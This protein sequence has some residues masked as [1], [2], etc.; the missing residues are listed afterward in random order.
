MFIAQSFICDLRRS[1]KNDLSSSILSSNLADSL[2]EFA[3]FLASCNYSQ[4]KVIKWSFYVI[5]MEGSLHMLLPNGDFSFIK[6]REALEMFANN[7]YLST[8]PITQNPLSSAIDFCTMNKESQPIYIFLPTCYSW[9]EEI[10]KT[11][12]RVNMIKEAKIDFTFVLVSDDEKTDINELNE[13]IASNPKINL[14]NFMNR[15]DC[16]FQFFR[17]IAESLFFH[18]TPDI[19]EIGI[20]SILCHK[21]PLLLPEVVISSV[22]TCTCHNL[23]SIQKNS[24]YCSVSNKKLSTSQKKEEYSLCGFIV[25]YNENEIVEPKFIV[26][27]RIDI[28][29]ISESMLIGATQILT[30]SD[31]KFHRI[32]NELRCSKEAFIAVRYPSN[33]F[34]G[35]YFIIIPDPSYFLLHCKKIG[36]RCQVLKFDLGESQQMPTEIYT[37][38]ISNEIP[39]IDEINPFMLGH[40]ELMR[41]FGKKI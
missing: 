15:D 18:P 37:N 33:V 28:K 10:T 16:F 17:S 38:E 22:S 1:D 39:K 36:N 40:E 25:P 11:L 9:D 35:E 41:C 19:L 29:K 23:P 3:L 5:D 12:N 13:K 2:W 7:Q 21:I 31:P 4:K 24:Y 20:H 27:G 32:I 34:G 26:K 14:V 8:L 30:S 6:I